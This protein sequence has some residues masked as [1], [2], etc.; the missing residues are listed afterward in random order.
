MTRTTSLVL[1][2]CRSDGTS[3]GG[4]QWPMEVGA[5]VIAPDWKN[6]AECGSGLHG[7]LY[8][9]GDHTCS[10]HWVHD[11]ARWMVLEVESSGI[12]MLGGKCKFERCVIR[13]VG[14]MA[15]AADYIAKHEPMAADVAIIGACKRVG[16]N[17]SVIVGA[18]GTAT[19]GDS[20]TATAGEAGTATAGGWG[21]A[22]AGEA[23]TA[24]AGGWGTAT[25]G[26]RGTATAGDSGTATAGSW[27]TATAGSWGT[28]TAG[29]AGELRINYW[30]DKSKRRRTALAYVGE[31]GIKPDAAY[32]LNDKHQFEEAA[33]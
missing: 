5:E 17:A 30:D 1:R 26:Y 13:F 31:N 29:E 7:W 27:G 18:M 9:Q 11:G 25:A 23:G 24:T 8:G 14:D 20:G 21:T 19:A 2:V 28:A 12:V 15:D 4:F 6:N 16:D 3:H 22:T 33:V 10:D 32:R